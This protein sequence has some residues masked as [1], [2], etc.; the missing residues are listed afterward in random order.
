MIAVGFA[1]VALVLFTAWLVDT[2]DL[3][4]PGWLE[5][6]AGSAFLLGSASLFCG[7]TYWLWTIAP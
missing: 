7:L 5:W 2:C 3:R 6:V 1:L 4:A